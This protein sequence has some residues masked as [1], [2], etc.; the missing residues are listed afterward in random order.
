M[1]PLLVDTDGSVLEAA[2][3][4]V[5]I[6]E[7]AALITPPAD[8][9]ILPGTVRAA[10]LAAEDRARQEPIDLLRLA[11]ADSVFLT[12]SIAGRSP[13]TLAPGSGVTPRAWRPRPVRAPSPADRR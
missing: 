3:A 13:A 6:T 4:N 8:G 2:H 7:G 9:R 1:V 10:L 11:L 5:W 12:S